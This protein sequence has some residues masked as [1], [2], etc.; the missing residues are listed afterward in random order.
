MIKMLLI[1]I[2]SG[3]V[4]VGCAQTEEPSKI[5]QANYYLNLRRFPEAIKILEKLHAE[6]M[7]NIDVSLLL[8][9]AYV[10]STGFN[11]VDAYE[12]F[13]PFFLADNS[14]YFDLSLKNQ[15]PTLSSVVNGNSPLE[16]FQLAAAQFLQEARQLMF[17]I[18]N[19][20]QISFS[21]RKNLV[22]SAKILEEVELF[23]LKD[24]IRVRSYSVL[25]NA[26][27]FANS[28]RD[29]IEV[30]RFL[31]DGDEVPLICFVQPAEFLGNIASAN[32]FL[33]RL[34]ADVADVRTAQGKVPLSD[35]MRHLSESSAKLE[36]NYNLHK[37]EIDAAVLAGGALRPAYCRQ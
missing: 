8:A 22:Q 24:V 34:L 4:A 16:K 5:D 28:L 37:E 30:S 3:T 18:R 7:E 23:E 33:S 6:E 9:S 12:A 35:G 2:L 31:D 15:A 20:P 26:L 11:V 14:Q 36:S 25:V 13:R 1:L 32:R 17:A 21:G 19:I 29:G 10:G 27:Q